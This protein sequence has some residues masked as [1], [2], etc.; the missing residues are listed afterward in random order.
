MAVG[1]KSAARTT[2]AA[3]LTARTVSGGRLVLS[4]VRYAKWPALI[5]ASY[6][7]L[8]HPSI[9]SDLLVELGNVLGIPAFLMLFLGWLLILLPI[10]FVLRTTVWFLTPLIKATSFTLGRMLIAVGKPRDSVR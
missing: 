5:G 1:S 6:I 7:V 9:V 2:K 8:A 4:G 10:L 3:G